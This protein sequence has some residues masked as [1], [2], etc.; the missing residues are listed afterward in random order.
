LLRTI[1]RSLGVVDVISN[2]TLEEKTV[3]FAALHTGGHSVICVAEEYDR[4]GSVPQVL[5]DIKTMFTR[6]DIAGVTR[7]MD[8]HHKEQKYNLWHVFKDEQR[9]KSLNL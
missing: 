2:V 7:L 6:E 8:K 1:K 9:I 5:K 4:P 3:M